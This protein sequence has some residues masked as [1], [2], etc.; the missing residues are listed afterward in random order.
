MRYLVFST[1]LWLSACQGTSTPLEEDVGPQEL[2]GLEWL[3]GSWRDRSPDVE[4]HVTW[5]WDGDKHFLIQRFEVEGADG[6]VFNGWQVLGWDPLKHQIHSW[7]FDSQGGFGE[8]LWEEDV[9]KWIAQ[10]AYTTSDGKRA[11]ATYI[12]QKIDANSYTFSAVNRNQDGEVLPNLGPYKM[13]R[14]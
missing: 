14:D 3:I 11:S 1:L 6:K 8:S 12:Y 2:K 13:V 7:I 4:V 5:N 9:N 10:S